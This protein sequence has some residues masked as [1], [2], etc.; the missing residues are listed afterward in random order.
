[1]TIQEALQR[2]T[3]LASTVC[4]YPGLPLELNADLHKVYHALRD[5]VWF[6]ESQLNGLDAL[7]A[8]LEAV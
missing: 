1:M 6:L 5:H 4:A 8:E 2:L 3:V 7:R